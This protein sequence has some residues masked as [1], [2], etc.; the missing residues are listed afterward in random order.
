MTHLVN[1]IG[2]GR[3]VI[4]GGWK[5]R[6]NEAEGRTHCNMPPHSGRQGE[7]RISLSRFGNRTLPPWPASDPSDI[8]VHGAPVMPKMAGAFLLGE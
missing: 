3:R 8:P 4:G 5:A 7:L 1:P 6:F 2:T